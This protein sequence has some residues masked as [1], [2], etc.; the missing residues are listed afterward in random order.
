MWSDRVLNRGPLTYESGALPTAL[1]GPAPVT[2]TSSKT[3][4][5]LSMRITWLIPYL[6]HS[7]VCSN[8][9]LENPNLKRKVLSVMGSIA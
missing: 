5:E 8:R 9:D 1:R 3:K 7:K 6:E 4:G 2:G